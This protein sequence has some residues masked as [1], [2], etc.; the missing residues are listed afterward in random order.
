MSLSYPVLNNKAHYESF[1]GGDP[2][3]LANFATVWADVSRVDINNYIDRFNRLEGT[4]NV[5]DLTTLQSEIEAS[6]LSMK[7]YSGHFHD[8]QVEKAA[9]DMYVELSKVRSKVES[10]IK[11][12]TKTAKTSLG[13]KI[14]SAR[15]GLK[16]A[17]NG[18]NKVVRAYDAFSGPAKRIDKLLDSALEDGGASIYKQISNLGKRKK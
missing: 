18:M 12:Y 5:A 15:R 7:S 6:Y 4:G 1:L 8:Y 3:R 11:I 9:N 17:K 16:K 14:M 13:R 10:E 2:K